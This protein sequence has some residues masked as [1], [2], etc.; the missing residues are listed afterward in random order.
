LPTSS[1]RL[2]SNITSGNGAGV[3]SMF[4]LENVQVL[5]GPQGTLFGRNTTGGA[6]LLVPRKP[7]GSL[8]GYVEG[9][10]GNYD[11]RRIQAVLNLP[12][13]DT[14]KVRLGVDRNR[15][16]GYLRNRS[17]IGPDD[18]NDVDY[19]AARLSIL[20]ELT[21]NLENYTIATYSR[22]DSNGAT[23]RIAFCSTTPGAPG[24][25][26]IVRSLMCAQLDRQ[27]ARGDGFY[28]IENSAPNAHVRQRTW[29]VINTTTWEFSDNLKLKNI[30]SYG[31]AVEAYSFN[32]T[33]DN[34]PF[35][36]VITNPG[37]NYGQGNQWTLSEE[38]QLQ[39]RSAN[40]RLVWQIGGYLERSK[41]NGGQEQ[42]TSIFANCTDVYAFKCTPLVLPLPT[43]PFTIG[44]V[45]IS[46]NVYF[47]RN[48][49]LYAQATY[50]L[51]DKFSF[52]GGV[53]YTWDWL[54]EDADSVVI[55][56]S[57][58]GPL[59]FRCSR[60]ITPANP[61]ARLARGGFCTRSF[62]EKSNAPTWLLDIDYKPNED[63]LIYAK[64]ARGYR[65]GGINEQN[66]NTEVWSPEKLDTYEIGLKSTFR[67]AVPGYLNITGFW[68]EFRNQQATVNIPACTDKPS[69]QPVGINGIQNVGKSRL[70]GI[71][72]EASLTFFRRLRFDAG[73][74][75]LDAKV[76]ATTPA[77]CSND[78]F[79]CAAATF[80][81]NVGD[82]LTFAP[83][84]RVTLTGTYTLPLEERLGELS[85]SAT[86]V[87][88][89]EQFTS[90]A[91][92]QAFAQG[93]IPF[94]S[95]IAPATD[96]L[97]LNFNWNGVAGSPVDLAL[98]ATNVTN[99][100]YFVGT[101]SALTTLGGEFL[102]LG[103]P[104]MYGARLRINFGQ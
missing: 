77:N 11:Q 69:C 34:S 8:E 59:A 27:N 47:Y 43:G 15:R 79:D 93:L 30:V 92:D 104:R 14:F 68:N 66:L 17:G 26:A 36:F 64:Y 91:N 13:A 25:N 33:G 28:D 45:S 6:I 49:A 103:Q 61:D 40:D 62:T 2:H 9:T 1:P 71:E 78:F 35:P 12:L 16:D 44:N 81:T 31:E 32:I 24:F 60:A 89:S 46:R 51:T 85:V 102:F 83:K 80:L 4:D 54:H 38:L 19:F 84:H 96:L 67:G 97:N 23:G 48:N 39:G 73:Y 72:A 90:H 88:T 50:D 10:V 29:Q 42:F 99:E 63:I 65:Q 58:T 3:G 56:P 20:A 94:N 86:F 75:Y 76:V 101:S 41:P 100:K 7:T 57:P 70:R 82:R 21:P 22:S 74:T 37:P 95:S 55:A 98:F 87:H 5:K 18:L 53:R 52:T